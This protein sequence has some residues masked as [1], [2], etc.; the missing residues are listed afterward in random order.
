MSEQQEEFEKIFGGL[1]DKKID[2][3]LERRAELAKQQRLEMEEERSRDILE[4]V[5]VRRQ[6]TRFK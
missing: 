4:Q 6:K 2:Q 3:E 5:R 1:I